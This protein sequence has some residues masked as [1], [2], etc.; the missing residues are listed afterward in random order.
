MFQN[1][2][3]RSYCDTTAE[4]VLK[5][6]DNT[7]YNIMPNNLGSGN[8]FININWLITNLIWYYRSVFQ[9]HFISKD[10]KGEIIWISWRSLDKEF[11]PP[12]V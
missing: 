6:P 9:I 10:N 11:I 4:L 8:L 2:E 1:K 12:T 3:Y 7:K 5:K